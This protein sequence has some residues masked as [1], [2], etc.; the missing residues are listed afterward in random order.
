MKLKVLFIVFLT[1]FTLTIAF[2]MSAFS[3]EKEQ[4]YW[5][6]SV[7][8][9]PLFLTH[10]YPALKEEAD[11]VG[12][13]IHFMGPQNIDIEMQNN[14]LQQVMAKNPNGILFMPF[15]EGHN[16][17]IDQVIDQGVPLVCIDGDAPNTKRICYS[18]TD[19]VELGRFQ[20]KLMAELLGGKGKVMLSAVIPNDNTLKARNGI[21]EEMAKHPDIEIVGLQNDQGSVIEAARLTAEAIQANPD[22]NGF[23]GIDAASGP[24]IARAIEEA[25]KTSQIKV[26]CVDNTPDIIEAVKK[27]TIQ[28]AV[29]QKREAFEIWGFRVLYE[30]NHPSTP[31]LEK[32]KEIGFAMVPKLILTGVLVMTPDNVD[33]VIDVLNYQEKVYKEMGAM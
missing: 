24:G 5:I 31:I 14:V 11:R 4:Y 28:A 16:T 2:T 23:I 19:W 10:D 1:V 25:G 26:V 17:V 13:E 15:G 3:Q 27:Q 20:A 12:A 8:T 32:Y 33:K 30:F 21:E 6:A 29:V 18:G 22:I 9:L 7:S